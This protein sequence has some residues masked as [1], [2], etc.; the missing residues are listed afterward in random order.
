MLLELWP[1]EADP[2]IF[3]TV[4]AHAAENA[5]DHE[6]D[7]QWLARLEG[8]E[9]KHRQALLGQEGR[10]RQARADDEVDCDA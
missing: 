10:Q 9:A 1:W 7:L 3:A 8:V 2:M 6:A 4:K 5:G